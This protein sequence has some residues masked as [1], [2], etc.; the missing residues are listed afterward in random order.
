MAETKKTEAAAAAAPPEAACLTLRQKLVEMRKACPEIVKKQHSDGVSYKYAK[1]YDVWE[2]ITPIMNELGVD[3]DVIS[4][5]ATRHA[6]NGDPVYW[7][8][9]QTKTRN[10]DKLMFLYEADLTIRWLN[11]DNDDE[12]IEATVH[13]VGWND[14]PAKAKG[15]AHTYALKYYLFEKFTVDQGEDDPDNSDFGAQGKG[16]GAGGRQQT[17][18]GRQG[19]GSG[20]LS[21]AQLARLYKKAEAAGMTKERTNAR[22]EE[23]YK[24]QDPATLTR[25]EYWAAS[26][27]TLSAASSLLLSA[28]GRD[29]VGELTG[30]IFTACVGYLITY[31]GKSLGEKIS[32]NR[33]RLDADGNPIPDPS[34]DT[35][36]NEEAQG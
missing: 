27:A 13:A 34:G 35:L 28:F 10:G 18:Q 5:Q 19:Q 2:K 9:M 31:A 14:D 3:F 4:E 33:H 15:A 16:S 7:I 1:I 11:L 6:E 8:T 12:T 36:N 24:K 20:R 17:A 30:T 21:D 26:V 25:Q 32:R 22:I 23:K 29:P